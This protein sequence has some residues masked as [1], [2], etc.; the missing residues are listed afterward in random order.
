MARITERVSE[1]S[2]GFQACEYADGTPLAPFTMTRFVWTVEPSPDDSGETT[3][4]YSN[5]GEVVFPVTRLILSDD[6]DEDADNSRNGT[7]ALEFLPGAN[8]D[9]D[10]D[11]GVVIQIPKDQLLDLEFN[12]RD[13]SVVLQLNDGFTNLQS[14]SVF[15][16]STQ[17]LA[18]VLPGEG[19]TMKAK[20][21]QSQFPLD[22]SLK[23]NA[24]DIAIEATEYEIIY[25]DSR[26]SI[27]QLKGDI[28]ANDRNYILGGNADVCDNGV[29]INCGSGLD[30]IIEGNIAGPVEVSNHNG[31]TSGQEPEVPLMQIRVNDPT[32]AS[33]SFDCQST[34]FL[35]GADDLGPGIACGGTNATVSSDPPFPC[36]RDRTSYLDVLVCPAD[37]L[38]PQDE[39]C[40]CTVVPP[41]AP[42][43]SEGNSGAAARERD[44]QRWLFVGLTMAI[45]MMLIL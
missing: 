30:L 10:G 37:P 20:A 40:E 39:T 41:P 25:I 7:V 1:L 28:L 35:F 22:L 27:I 31:F 36:T 33:S 3:V 12:F 23:G 17:S 42:L 21:T 45:M 34:F 6:D 24:M 44:N 18:H 11:V 19:P 2:L 38:T 29:T 43:S 32:A 4:I 8:V 13:S 14:L 16:S 9:A 26:N 15:A 5:G